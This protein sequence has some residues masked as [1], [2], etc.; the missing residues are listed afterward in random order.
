MSGLKTSRS[1]S[2]K[3]NFDWV[4]PSVTKGEELRATLSQLRI[5]ITGS[6]THVITRSYK[7]HSQSVSDSIIVP[8]Y[9]FAEWLLH[10]WWFVFHEPEKK[11]DSDFQKR[12]DWYF[13]REGYSFPHLTFIPDGS[14]ISLKWH[15]S[16]SEHSQTQFLNTGSIIVDSGQLKE[17]LEAFI[18]TTVHRLNDLGLSK[19][20]LQEAWAEHL[21]LET[22]EVEFC[23]VVAAYGVNPF[24]VSDE[25]SKFLFEVDAFLGKSASV[26]FGSAIPVIHTAN[27]FDQVK[28][29]IEKIGV[30]HHQ[31]EISP[32]VTNDFL[33]PVLKC[34]SQKA[35][36]W[37]RGYEDAR[38][39]R[40]MLNIEGLPFESS[41][42]MRKSF[43]KKNIQMDD[44]IS[45][46]SL[47]NQ[48]KAIV[49]VEDSGRRRIAIGTSHA[50]DKSFQECRAIYPH[51][52][53]QTDLSF[54]TS[55]ETEFQKQNR[56][57]AAEFLMPASFLRSEIPEKYVDAERVDEI[58][59]EFNLSNKV[60]RLQIQNH[61]IATIID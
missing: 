14:H 34:P 9:P 40:M 54:I 6:I 30:R 55:S 26:E 12:H 17:E 39:L 2:L 5:E 58:A 52:L 56:A 23:E 3:I 4:D 19:T 32:T 48:I 22:D 27:A 57:F 37:E 53:G 7:K 15:P 33:K 29:W 10:N 18:S 60:V 51:I 16:G 13:G 41:T 47:P 8:T 20:E 31:S 1:D 43:M 28:S 25:F 21:Q 42:S 35:L 45:E 24:Q 59:E 46:A 61:R 50:R 49:G 44:F 11:N 38:E 36:P